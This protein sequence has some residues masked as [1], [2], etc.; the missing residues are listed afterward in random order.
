MKKIGIL[1]IVILLLQVCLVSATTANEFKQDWLDAKTTR[2]KLA[3]DH[4]QAKLE[5][6]ANKSQENNQKVIDTAK[7]VLTAVLD[8]AEIWLHWKN[9]EA[10]ENP[11]VPED[12]KLSIEQDVNLNIEKIESLKIEVDGIKTNLDAGLVFL[13][14][15]GK[16]F[17]LLTD[18][19]R[20][21][22]NMWVH[23][24][25][26]YIENL[27]AYEQKVRATAEKLG[28]QEIL[29]KLDLAKAELD[30]AKGKIVLATT[31]YNQV[32]MPGTPLKKFGEG[33]NYLRQAKENMVN[34]FVQV[35]HAFNLIQGGSQ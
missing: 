1:I 5:Y 13:K 15:V 23:I 11:E 32:K 4:K 27:D 9:Q 30:L 35:Q 18:V 17:E 20:N 25:E 16:Y 22:G 8:E 2:F 33:N 34:S 6:A 19:A 21:S 12:I 29:N 3:E 26:N 31:A 10:K 14:M 28:D 7:I 24:A